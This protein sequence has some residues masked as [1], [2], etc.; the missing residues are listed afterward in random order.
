MP[1]VDYFSL[2]SRSLGNS[3]GTNW[4]KEYWIGWYWVLAGFGRFSSGYL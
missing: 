3:R 4:L 1:I 2:I